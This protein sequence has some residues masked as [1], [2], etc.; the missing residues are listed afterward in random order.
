MI[1]FENARDLNSK[2][3]FYKKNNKL[4]KKIARNCYI[5]AN[6]IFNNRIIAEFMVKKT[7]GE[8]ITKKQVWH[9]D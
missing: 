4:R 5:K 7:L 1:F 9:D 6:K 3:L 2:I 8:K